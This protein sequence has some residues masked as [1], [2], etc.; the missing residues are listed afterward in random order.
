M[1]WPYIRGLALTAGFII[2]VLV[3]V[4]LMLGVAELVIG[5]RLER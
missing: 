3:I 2:G 5:W 1:T 4:L